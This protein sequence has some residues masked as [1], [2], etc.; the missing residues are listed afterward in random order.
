MC[1]KETLMLKRPHDFN[2]IV[3]HEVF[4]KY[5]IDHIQKGNLPRF[6][7]LEGPTGLGKTSIAEVVAV[8][9]N[10]GFD[11]TPERL[12]AITDVI[13]NSRSTDCIK[14]YNMGKD[15][16]KDTAKEV[17]AE[18]S[19]AMSTTGRKV[20]LCDECHAILE[21]AQDTFL[22]DT[23][24]IPKNV[25]LIMMTTDASKLKMTLRSRAVILSLMNL[26]TNEMIDV[27]EREVLRK[28]L[29]IQGGK[30][31][32]RMIAE[33]A[34]NKPRAALNIL[35]AFGENEIVSTELVREFIGYIS[36]EDIMPLVTS[37][38]GSMTYGLSYIS[39]LRLNDTLVDTLVEVLRIKLGQPS[40]RVSLEEYH[41]ARK[42]LEAVPQECIM[43]FL[44]SI[45]ALPRIN[46]AG[47][48]SAYVSA[49]T[50]YDRLFK[51][52]KSVLI[53]EQSQKLSNR[54]LAPDINSRQSCTAPTIDSL[55]A[56]SEIISD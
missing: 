14:K 30:T 47:L 19:P 8:T 11:N 55:L 40:F 26:K 31:T 6:I 29:T 46:R 38:S 37:L 34:D 28:N 44:H 18:L 4:K 53:E 48:I 25:W 52:D 12:K 20:V 41:K 56:D 32:L 23:E 7:I 36:L 33:W 3:G 15:S 42:Q 16:G 17:L 24:F 21:S 45:A 43:K 39:E 49:H 1:R 27:L 22:V 50:S 51:E 5:F 13:D 10:Y 54:A 35:N 2:E 9:L